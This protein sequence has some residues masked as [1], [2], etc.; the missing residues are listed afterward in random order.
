MC[1]GG[2][3]SSLCN[4]III[5]EGSLS[6]LINHQDIIIF[7]WPDHSYQSSAHQPYLTLNR[8]QREDVIGH[9]KLRLAHQT[10]S[11]I[12]RPCWIIINGNVNEKE[13]RER[14]EFLQIQPWPRPYHVPQTSA[15]LVPN[16]RW[17]RWLSNPPWY[18]WDC[19][20]DNMT[21]TTNISPYLNRQLANWAPQDAEKNMINWFFCVQ[22]S[23]QRFNLTPL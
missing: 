6:K 8:C 1:G 16:H 17:Q 3:L 10:R 12:W 4:K 20:Q 9:K 5:I 2:R 13:M 14:V 19:Q 23:K 22:Q 7:H 21:P 18:N 11:H 15:L